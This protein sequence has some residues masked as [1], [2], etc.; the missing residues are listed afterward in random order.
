MLENNQLKTSMLPLWVGELKDTPLGAISV[1][2]S[3]Q[4]LAHLAFIPAD[5]LISRLNP[6]VMP[7]NQAPPFL[8]DALNQLGGYLSGKCRQF[9]LPIDWSGHSTFDQT[10]RRAAIAI[11]YGDTRSYGELA[12]EAGKASAARA[13]GGAMNRNP[14]PLII[15]CHRVVDAQG[16]L[17]GYSATGGLA[18]K[19]WLL[20][21]EGH[22]VVKNKLV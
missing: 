7:V 22:T 19:A 4:G 1:A 11:P 10:V 6:Q 2:V 15:P 12:M 8:A 5:A 20:E 17:T 3:A 21:L 13:V 14:L 16:R 9:N 18:T